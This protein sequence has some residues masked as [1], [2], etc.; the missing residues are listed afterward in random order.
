MWNLQGSSRILLVCLER[1]GKPF[2]EPWTVSK[3]LVVLEHLSGWASCGTTTLFSGLQTFPELYSMSFFSK[4]SHNSSGL[5]WCLKQTSKP[6]LA[7]NIVSRHSPFPGFQSCSLTST[8]TFQ[9]SA[10]HFRGTLGPVPTTSSQNRGFVH[11][12]CDALSRTFQD[13]CISS[14]PFLCVLRGLGHQT[15]NPPGHLVL[16]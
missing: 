12:I 14:R 5:S 7:W 10:N 15:T 16:S 6:F 11:R 2:Q 1:I 4:T 8:R 9:M 13:C 3:E